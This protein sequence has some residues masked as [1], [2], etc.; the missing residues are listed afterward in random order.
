MGDLRDEIH[1]L[2]QAP[3]EEEGPVAALKK[4]NEQLLLTVGTLRGEK[5]KAEDRCGEVAR[6][7]ASLQQQNEQA[8][9]SALQSF[10]VPT[11]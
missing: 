5:H 6:A 4:Q 3:S 10:L 1:C 2:R 7:M 8:V 9:L 11:V